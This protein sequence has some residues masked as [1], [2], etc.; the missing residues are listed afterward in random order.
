MLFEERVRK[1][2]YKL[3]DT[4]DQII[5]YISSH[6]EIV[7]NQSIQ[8]LAAN[9]YTAPNTIVRL[10]KKLD[11]DGF[12]QLK[13]QLKEEIYSKENIEDSLYLY[14]KKTYEIMDEQKL[15]QISKIFGKANQI[16][17]YGIGDTVPFVESMV[18]RFKNMGVRIS[19]QHHRHEVVED[20]AT[21]FRKGDVVFLIS[22]SGESQ[23]VLEIAKLAK[24]KGITVI[25]LTH[26]TH[27]SLADIADINLF[28]YSPKRQIGIHDMEL[29]SP[30]MF[31][32]EILGEYYLKNIE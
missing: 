27:N 17:S 11:Y 3:N 6:K 25:S 19:F 2:E 18:R 15:K 7:I 26:F 32:I 22:I 13:I 20:I 4:D 28:C 14:I 24:A 9:V 1:F 21:I 8:V 23:Q 31:A 5:E 10:S 29:K 30:L 16:M 12:S